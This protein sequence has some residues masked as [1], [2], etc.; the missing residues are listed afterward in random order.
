MEPDAI[1]WSDPAASVVTNVPAAA[2][3]SGAEFSK[4]IEPVRSVRTDALGH[5]PPSRDG[6]PYRVEYGVRTSTSA[7]V[8]WVEESGCW[9]AVADGKPARAQGIVPINNESPARDQQLG[10]L[11]RHD[12]LTGELNR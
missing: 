2:L 5:S 11:S 7:P 1:A 9:F 10:R 12:P 6:A 3:A 4:L 8:L